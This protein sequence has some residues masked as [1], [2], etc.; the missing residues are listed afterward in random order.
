MIDKELIEV[1]QM[2]LT[3]SRGMLALDRHPV[4]GLNDILGND[5]LLRTTLSDS[6]VN[7]IHYDN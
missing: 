1:V 4:N 2:F 5:L 3:E 7:I 6:S